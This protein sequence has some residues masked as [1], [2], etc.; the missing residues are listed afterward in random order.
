M[1]SASKRG[2]RSCR[3]DFSENLMP[4]GRRTMLTGLAGISAT[5]LIGYAHAA[6][7]GKTLRAAMTGFTT[8]NT[9]DPGKAAVNPEF[10]VI[11]GVFNTLVKFDADMKVVGD[12]AESW[13]NPDPTTW[14]FKL[15]RGVK[16]HDGSDL[17]ADDVVF[18]FQRIADEKFAS[19]V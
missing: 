13:S 9:L 16:F 1:S 17:T 11:W 10:F 18:T 19:P 12:L 8:I 7:E 2:A 4:F 6:P 3:A 14:E 5:G 15:H